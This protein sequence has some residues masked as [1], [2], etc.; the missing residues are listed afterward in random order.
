MLH[1]IGAL[2][3]HCTRQQNTRKYVAECVL[4]GCVCV[5]VC[6]MQWKA[7]HATRSA[8][9]TSRLVCSIHFWG[10]NRFSLIYAAPRTLQPCRLASSFAKWRHKLH[11]AQGQQSKM[12]WQ[13]AV[14]SPKR[15]AAAAVAVASIMAA[16]C[17]I[18][19]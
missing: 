9:P 6:L 17:G 4:Y 7:L 15:A 10:I 2:S 16:F 14:V 3:C 1:A 12:K 13:V 5:C 8:P 11:H 19:P 18:E